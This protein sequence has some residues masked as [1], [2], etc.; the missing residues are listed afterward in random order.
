MSKQNWKLYVWPANNEDP[1]DYHRVLVTYSRELEQT[2][3][4]TIRPE[5]VVYEPLQG[6]KPSKQSRV[7]ISEIKDIFGIG[8][9]NVPI[10][11]DDSFSLE[12]CAKQLRPTHKTEDGSMIVDNLDEDQITDPWPILPVKNDKQRRDDGIEVNMLLYHMNQDTAIDL[13]TGKETLDKPKL[14][15]YSEKE[16]IRILRV[17]RKRN[18]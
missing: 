6:Y 15:M 14:F 10:D 18:K 5:D 12:N 2:L 1:Y 9:Y 8:H 4:I 16:P 3:F 17:D 13:F 7:T 11:N